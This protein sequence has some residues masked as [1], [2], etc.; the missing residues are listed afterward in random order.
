[1]PLS[2][3]HIITLMARSM[4]EIFANPDPDDP[5]P[6]SLDEAT[7]A[8]EALVQAGFLIVP[9]LVED[10]ELKLVEKLFPTADRDA[11]ADFLQSISI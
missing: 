7:V 11:V 10:S 4:D 5:H 2:R 3:D 8:Y 1:M 6:L 9:R